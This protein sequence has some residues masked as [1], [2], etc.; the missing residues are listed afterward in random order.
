LERRFNLP[1]GHRIEAS[2]EAFNALNR[3]NFLNPNGTF[4]SGTTPP[5]TFGQPSVA[6]DPRQVQFGLRWVF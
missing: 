1:R 4:G 2:I 6:N 5:A 3:T